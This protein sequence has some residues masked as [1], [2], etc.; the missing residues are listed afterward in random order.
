MAAKFQNLL[1][2]PAPLWGG[3]RGGGSC[4][5]AGYVLEHTVN[6]R[7]NVERHA[8]AAR[9]APTPNPSPQGIALLDIGNELELKTNS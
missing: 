6:V 7:H 8:V 4:Y 3:V 9:F 5:F 2:S 1:Q